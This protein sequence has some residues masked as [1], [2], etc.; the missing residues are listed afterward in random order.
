MSEILES[1]ESWRKIEIRERIRES[2]NYLYKTIEDTIRKK[3]YV[4]FISLQRWNK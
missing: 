1:D 3:Y 2:R 4:N